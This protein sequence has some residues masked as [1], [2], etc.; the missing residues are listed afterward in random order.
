MCGVQIAYDHV[1]VTVPVLR[2]HVKL[3]PP[4]LVGCRVPLLTE[5]SG[6]KVK[7]L[8]SFRKYPLAE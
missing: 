4:Q 1:I 5:S 6:S 2:W 3:P 7:R 8:T